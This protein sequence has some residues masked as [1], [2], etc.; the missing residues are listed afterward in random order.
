MA[1]RKVKEKVDPKQLWNVVSH[2]MQG[3]H[4][5]HDGGCFCLLKIYIYGLTT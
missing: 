1:E 5:H 2:Q 4:S 3:F